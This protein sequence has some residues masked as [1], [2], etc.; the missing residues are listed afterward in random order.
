MK[1][2]VIYCYK[3]SRTSLKTH[4]K[5]FSTV[6]FAVDE[7]F[8]QHCLTP[9]ADTSTFWNNWL[10][11]NPDKR[12]DWDQAV[13]LVRAVQEGLTSYTR[14][15]LSEDAEAL[16]LNRI[17]ATNREDQNKKSVVSIR[18]S[19]G[20]KSL[21]AAASIIFILGFAGYF[22]LKTNEDTAIYSHQVSGLKGEILEKIN[23]TN[24]MQV[25]VLPDH[26]KISLAPLS[27]ISYKIGQE[28]RI[29]FLS[30][31]A[32][33]DV[34]KDPRKPFLVYA[35]ET[36]TRVLG[37]RFEVSAFENDLE[38]V[39]KVQTGKVTVYENKE[40]Y[41]A[42]P[43]RNGKTGV[44]LLP[45]Q[46]VAF[47]RKVQQFNKDIV[48]EPALIVTPAETPEFIYDDIPVKQVFREIEKAYGIEIDFN[49]EALVNCH[50]TASLTEESLM[51]K[52]DIIC[53]SIG[54]NY[55]I[56]EARI[57]INSKGCESNP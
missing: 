23:N 4:Y 21:A 8:L 7:A 44:L 51:E 22:W 14:T 33:F 24:R 18:K 47:K 11:A 37:T 43:E 36:V 29:V 48:A 17:L 6:D 20:F 56:V 54:A 26:S 5:N 28:S 10:N 34:V 12:N 49:A 39:V 53:S 50:L 32:V 45:N 9:S 15:Y 3:T 19:F 46:Q 55:E 16:L 40:I 13:M 57:I 52:L 1:P 25:Y 42:D 27:R 38:V 31:K 41:N 30:G 2:D 35:N